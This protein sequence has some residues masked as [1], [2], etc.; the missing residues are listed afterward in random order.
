MANFGTTGGDSASNL[1]ISTF[2]VNSIGKNPKRQQ[3]FNF[4]STKKSDIFVLVDTRISKDLE[5]TVKQEWGSSA[6]FSCLNSQARGVA[7]LFKKFVCVEVLKEKN[8]PS[9]NILFLLLNF[10]SKK[11]L[12]TAIYGPNEDN[13]QFYKEKVFNLID[14]WDPD[15]AI[16]AGDWNLVLNQNLDTKNYLHKNNLRARSEL[17]NKMEYFSLID[18]WRELNPSAKKYTWTGKASRPYKFSRLDFFLISNSL[19]PFIKKNIH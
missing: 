12:L 1:I 9:G 3:I 4:L 16:Y 6:Y 5:D 15:F 8:D 11:I 19:F 10:D 17:K 7:I 2:N 18:V 14:E 13:P